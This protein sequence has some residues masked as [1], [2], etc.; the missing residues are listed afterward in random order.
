MGHCAIEKRECDYDK[1]KHNKFGCEGFRIDQ[2]CCPTF[3]LDILNKKMREARR[4][5]EYKWLTR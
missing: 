1:F 3:A 5:E 2:I 4:E